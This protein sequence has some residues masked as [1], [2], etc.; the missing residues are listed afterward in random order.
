VTP[1]GGLLICEDGSGDQW[2]RGLTPT[3]QI[4]DFAMNIFN[5]AEFAGACFGHNNT[6]YVNI[7]GSTAGSATAPGV[8]GS[9]M[10]LAIWGPWKQGP[11]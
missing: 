6:L 4:F 1:Q 9:G 5:D 2:L 8:K 3:G 7:Q 10:T 11:L